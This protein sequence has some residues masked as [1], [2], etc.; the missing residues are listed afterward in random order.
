MSKKQLDPS[1]ITVYTCYAGDR[2]QKQSLPFKVRYSVI[3]HNI[4]DGLCYPSSI[5]HRMCYQTIDRKEKCMWPSCFAAETD[6]YPRDKHYLLRHDIHGALKWLI[7]DSKL[8]E[9]LEK[10]ENN[11]TKKKVS[12]K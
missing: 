3:P 7:E 4:D 12:K 8:E 1:E 6:C 2:R 5:T 9:Y 10:Q 11:I